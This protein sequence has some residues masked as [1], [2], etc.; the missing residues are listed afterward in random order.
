VHV[1]D[2]L[3]GMVHHFGWSGRYRGN[4]PGV[5]ASRHVMIGPERSLLV[6][7]DAEAFRIDPQGVVT[8]IDPG[9]AD[10][11]LGIIERRCVALR[12]GASWQNEIFHRLYDKGMERTQAL[13][14]MTRLYREHMHANVP[15]H[16]WPVD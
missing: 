15:V 16:E 4:T 6:A 3:N 1:A 10:R 14:R 2:P 12:N 11:L 13:R 8:P 5:G 9:D 7:G